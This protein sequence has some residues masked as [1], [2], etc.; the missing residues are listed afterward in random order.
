MKPRVDAFTWLRGLHILA[1]LF[2]RQFVKG[3]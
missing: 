2:A 1:V 3:W